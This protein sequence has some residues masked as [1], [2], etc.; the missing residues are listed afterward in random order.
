M[1]TE[2][3]IAMVSGAIVPDPLSETIAAYY[4]GLVDFDANAP[5]DDAGADAYAAISY[6]PHM[7][8][9]MTWVEPART[10]QSAVEALRLVV[11]SLAL[12]E[13]YVAA[14][15][16]AA[17]LAFFEEED[18]TACPVSR[19]FNLADLGRR[20]EQAKADAIP[21]SKERKRLYEVWQQECQSAGLP[22]R[23]TKATLKLQKDTGFKAVDD[24]FT[25][26]HTEAVRLMKAIHRAKATTLEGFAVKVAA[27][28]FDQSDFEVSDPVPTDVAER[29]L[30]RLARSM[31]KVVATN[32][33]RGVPA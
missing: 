3:S 27:I 15:M 12:G 22:D 29:E 19:D 9:L 6:A 7:D 26:K 4:A 13:D 16:A 1:M 24:A 14:P 5:G 10:R 21:L 28:A 32:A 11:S 17:A 31:A 33:K 20:F 8:R 18:R 23:Y 25:A 2:H 30:Y